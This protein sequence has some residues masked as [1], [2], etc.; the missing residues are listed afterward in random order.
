MNWEF[1]LLLFLQS[2]SPGLI[3][4]MKGI[5]FL[6]NEQFYL[7]VLPALYWCIS[8]EL[9]IRIAVISMFSGVINTYFKWMFHSPRPF[10]ASKDI[11]P[12]A[13]ETSFGIPSGH[14]Q[15]AVAV[16]GLISIKVKQ[17]WI[18]ILAILLIFLIGLSRLVL[19]V[20][21]PVDVLVGWLIGALVLGLFIFFEKPLF[22]KF[23]ESTL[24]NKILLITSC[25]LILILLGF[26]IHSSASGLAIPENW[27]RNAA[28]AFPDDVGLHPFAFS[29]LI[30]SVAA[31]T[32]L[33]LG[34]F[35]TTRHNDFSVEAEFWKL[36][37]RY[38]VGIIGVIV[39][40]AGLDQL[41]PD[42]ETF[43]PLLF[44]FIRYGLVGF[45]VTAGAP[46]LFN[47]LGLTRHK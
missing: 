1:D 7:L 35:V 34:H 24:S 36:V 19:G 17:Y 44:R 5:T 3:S 45:W 43:I 2:L 41:F 15:N 22:K 13:H 30:T 21:F 39:I 37:L 9:G 38:F 10:W 11:T 14:A 8:I 28:S 6:G 31:L 26:V 42:G 32:G 16:W 27:A 29:S 46:I 20:H 40:W 23:E 33:L 25:A 4:L 47:K 12:Y 18:K